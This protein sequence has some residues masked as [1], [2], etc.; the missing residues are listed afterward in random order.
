MPSS[1]ERAVSSGSS[2]TRFLDVPD[3]LDLDRTTFARHEERG[4]LIAIPT[5]P[6]VPVATTSP[7]RA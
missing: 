5:P 4:G 1:S 7:A 3:A 2:T 6:G